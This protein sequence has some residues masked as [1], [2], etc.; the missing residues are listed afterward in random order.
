MRFSAECY[1]KHSA[2]F[3]VYNEGALTGDKFRIRPV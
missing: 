1:G 2:V 3:V